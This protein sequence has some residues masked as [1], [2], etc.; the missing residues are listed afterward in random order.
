MSAPREHLP[1]DV[2]HLVPAYG[3]GGGYGSIPLHQYR[4]PAF[5]PF[6]RL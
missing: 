4:L 1:A 5:K 6:S 3:R 2:L